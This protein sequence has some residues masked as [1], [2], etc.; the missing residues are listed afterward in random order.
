MEHTPSSTQNFVAFLKWD[1]HY[2]LDYVFD[3]FDA[4][5][6]VSIFILLREENMISFV[7]CPSLAV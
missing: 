1:K 6:I 7:I 2:L 3:S 4:N 5:A